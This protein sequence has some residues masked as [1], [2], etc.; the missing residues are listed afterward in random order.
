M[1]MRDA[2]NI[3]AIVLLFGA[4]YLLALERDN[5]NSD[6]TMGIGTAYN[7]GNIPLHT[8][9]KGER[10]VIDHSNRQVPVR[11]YER[12]L[13]A[14]ITSKEIAV[15]LVEPTRIAGYLAYGNAGGAWRYA[16]KPTI[17]EL[18]DTEHVIALHP[19]IVFYSG[20]AP[21]NALA[22]LHERGI[23]TFD[24]GPMT[25]LDSYLYAAQAMMT[26]MDVRERAQR[27]TQ[28]LQRRAKNVACKRHD[29][30]ERA[31][32]LSYISSVLFGGTTHTSYHDILHYAG[33]R[34]IA[35]S[36]YQG[37]PQYSDEE[38]VAMDPDW[39][40]TTEGTADT[41]CHHRALSGLSACRHHGAR[42]IQLPD[43]VIN[44]TG[45][46]IVDAAAML[47]DA[48]YGPCDAL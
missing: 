1:T 39:I 37:W 21:A 9:A 8:N 15:E 34:D 20:P 13:A 3:V 41:L 16:G 43:D 45:A 7:A 19:D 47:H 12:V 11:P 18:A 42:I 2:L 17:T 14:S 5:T 24:H 31:L 4:L 22:R 26:V 40:V 32:Y 35:A 23:E 25:G 6:T 29:T 44:G 30:P 10:F 28:S 36:R 38:L 48:I 33:L 46:G 27:Y